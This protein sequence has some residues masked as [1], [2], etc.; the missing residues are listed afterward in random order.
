MR[1]NKFPLRRDTIFHVPQEV[2]VQT[3][4]Y[5]RTAGA[6][7]RECTVFWGGIGKGQ[8]ADIRSVYCPAQNSTAASVEVV[9][10][11][12]HEMYKLLERRNEILL[13]QV[14]SH[15]GTAFHSGTD[16]SFP[17]TF[18]VGFVS[19]VVP[20]FCT[21]GLNEFRDCAVFVHEGRGLWG[22]M[23]KSNIQRQ[24]VVREE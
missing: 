12:V 9:P 21:A 23:D 11:A 15:P 5:L 13:A 10:D 1:E 3:E 18:L 7:K 24:L 22:K 17:A 2:L 20:H 6:A 8:A 4:R 16:D 14:H 19:I